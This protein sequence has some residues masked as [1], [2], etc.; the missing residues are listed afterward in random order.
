MAQEEYLPQAMSTKLPQSAS[1][2]ADL[3][4]QQR[5]KVEPKLRTLK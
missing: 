5:L 3:I 1:H 4:L 2:Q